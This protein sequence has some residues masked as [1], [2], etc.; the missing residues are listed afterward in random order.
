[1][2]ASYVRVIGF[3][4]QIEALQVGGNAVSYTHL[5]VYKRQVLIPVYLALFKSFI[6]SLTSADFST[7]PSTFITRTLDQ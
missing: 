4:T 3:W 6:N 2:S 1:M 5:D 7:S